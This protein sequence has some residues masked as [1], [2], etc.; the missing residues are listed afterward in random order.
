MN[1]TGAYEELIENIKVFNSK[2]KTSSEEYLHEK[3]FPHVL[4]LRIY[5]INKYKENPEDTIYKIWENARRS[6]NFNVLCQLVKA[7]LTL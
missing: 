7:A 1:F 4:V 6:N 5:G 3:L 2:F